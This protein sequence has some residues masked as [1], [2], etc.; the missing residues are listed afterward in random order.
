M[1]HQRLGEDRDIAVHV[2]GCACHFPLH[3]GQVL[4]YTAINFAAEIFHDLRP[5]QAPPVLR[6]GHFLAVLQRQRIGQ[7]RKRVGFGFV[8]VGVIWRVLVASVAAAADLGHVQQIHQP[9]MIFLRRLPRRNLRLGYHP[10]SRRCTCRRLLRRLKRQHYQGYG[11]QRPENR[12]WIGHRIPPSV[13][14]TDNWFSF[15]TKLSYGENRRSR[16]PVRGPAE[17]VAEHRKPCVSADQRR[18]SQNERNWRF[19]RSSPFTGVA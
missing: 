1:S 7:H 5:P 18:S 17:A 3:L 12:T 2:L 14:S 13:N 11:G 8:V 6:G 15:C 19:P 10:A 4:R 9:L 16:P